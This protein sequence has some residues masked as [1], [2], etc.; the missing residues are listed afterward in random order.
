MKKYFIHTGFFKGESFYSNDIE[1]VNKNPYNS[2][3]TLIERK[4]SIT[5]NLLIGV[6][7]SEDKYENY[8]QR[9]VYVS[10]QTIY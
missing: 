5:A 8:N 6:F 7:Y 3:V 10:N 4:L 2:V 9:I 1:S